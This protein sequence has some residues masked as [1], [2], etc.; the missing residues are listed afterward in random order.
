MKKKKLW[1]AILVAFVVLVSSVVYL[2][3]AVIFQRGNPIPYLTAAARISEKNPYVA[4]NEAKGIYISKRGECPELLEYYQEK[5]GM[6]FVEQ[7]GS[8]YLFTDGSRNEVASSEVYWGRYTVW[9]LP[10]M[11][12]A[13]NF[14]AEQYDAKPVIYLYPEKKAEVTV[15]LNYAGELT[16]TYPAYNDGWKVCASPDGTLTDADG[17]TYN[18]LY[19]EG[20]NSVAYDFSEGFCVAGSD[21]AAF[22]ENA[23]NQLG[24]TR[25][26]A[27]E[28]IVYW[29]PLMKG[30]PYNLIAFQSDSYTQAAQLSIEP[31]PDTLLRVFM[32]WMP[33]ESAVDISTQN[34]TAP[35]RTGFTAVEWGGC[36]VR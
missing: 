7:A 20:V 5:A 8:S 19:W 18:Y 34:L 10:T 27:N 29:L 6:E 26:E 1:I 14:D 9:V 22:L 32:A 25:K 2:N 21:T 33:L 13:E 17:Q 23:L 15:K 24:L 3:R 16:C 28:F 11:E 36:Q 12:A 35:V 31:A 4:V 30:N